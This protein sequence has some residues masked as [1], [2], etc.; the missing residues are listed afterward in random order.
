MN[1]DFAKIEEKWHCK[2]ESQKDDV[3]NLVKDCLP[4]A[5]IISKKDMQDRDRMIFI[6]EK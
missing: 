5:T 3:I 6:Y 1:Y 4:Q 2:Y